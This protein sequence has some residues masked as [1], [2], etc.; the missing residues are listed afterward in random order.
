MITFLDLLNKPLTLIVT[1]VSLAGP[2]A[3]MGTSHENFHT[4]GSGRWV[5]EHYS[6]AGDGAA[7]LG[8]H[9]GW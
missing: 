2:G 3:K 6:F 7:G 9:V 1:G 8:L 5:D 4:C